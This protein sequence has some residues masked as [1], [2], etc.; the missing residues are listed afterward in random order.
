MTGNFDLD[1]IINVDRYP[2]IELKNRASELVAFVRRELEQDGACTLPDFVL[3]EAL[4]CMVQQAEALTPLAYPGPREATPYFFNYDLNGAERV[5]DDHPLRRTTRRN[6]AQV[7][8]DLIPQEH[9][10]NR[11]YHAPLMLRFLGCVLG[12]PAFRN[13]DLYQGLNISVMKEGGCQQWHFDAG[14]MVTT[15][16]LQAPESGGIFEYVPGLRSEHNENFDEVKKV[17][18]G[19]RERVRQLKLSAGT[20]A[21][22]RGHYS[23]HRVTPVKGQRK[24][25]QAI[26]GY[27]TKPGFKGSL[28]SSILHYGPRVASGY[29]T[30]TTG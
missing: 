3:E 2:L 20:L 15:L 16:L 21:L 8:G 22:F 11:L 18:D 7:A 29:S 25:L 26:L 17:L 28:K 27:T 30:R 10:L 23:L 14:N 4:V 24:R 19:E 9:L 12:Q 13:A 6:L 5:P 1:Q